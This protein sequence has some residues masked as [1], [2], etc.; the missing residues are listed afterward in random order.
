MSKTTSAKIPAARVVKQIRQLARKNFPF[1]PLHVQYRLIL[2]CLIELEAERRYHL[3][4][5]NYQPS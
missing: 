4:K 5:E 3:E 1:S 2:E